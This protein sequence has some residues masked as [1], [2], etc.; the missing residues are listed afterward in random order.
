MTASGRAAIVIPAYEPTQALA[1]VVDELAAD[2]RDIIVV[3]DGSSP[4]AG[5][6]FSQIA[7]HR[8]VVI[9]RHAINLGKGQAL[10]TAFNYFLLHGSPLASG[11]VTAD[12]DGQHLATDIRRVAEALEASP[13]RLILGTRRFEGR[14]PF[15]SRIGNAVT[16]AMFRMLLGRSVA[17]TQSG[18]RGIPRRFLVE[19]LTI[20]AGRYEYE[21][22]VLI[23]AAKRRLPI[24]AVPIR[25]VYGGAGQ[26]HF[27]VLR[28]SVRIYFVFV[29]FLGLSLA[30]AALDYAV[31]V[32]AYLATR[33]LLAS[34]AIARTVA[35]TFNFACNRWFVFR[36]RGRVWPQA[37]KYVVLVFSL[38]WISYAIV[39]S[40]I[41][42]TGVGVYIAKLLGDGA[43]FVA[44]FAVQQSLVFPVWQREAGP[45]ASTDWD[46]YYRQPARFAWITR[47]VTARR[48]LTIVDRFMPA[49]AVRHVVEL[50]GGNSLTLA[51]FADH[52]PEARLTAVDANAFGLQLLTE[53]VAGDARLVTV[54]ADALTLPPTFSADVVY[55]T[56]L[57]EHFA[58]DGTARAVAAHFD[59]VRPGGLV[60]ITYPTP[61]W[62]Y[63]LVRAGATVL[64]V[65]AFPDERPL[66]HDEVAR[67]AARHGRVLDLSINW[68]V[69]LTQGVLVA[70]RDLQS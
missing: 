9:L 53:R 35:G 46:R 4:G 44:S 6:L 39:T 8:G 3:D 32:A 12:A 15:R 43:L 22:E 61:T 25:T 52:Y 33:H 10:K 27:N 58:P 55:S 64:G 2:G 24:D 67:E 40:L 5:E 68:A 45:A 23:R 29:R 70:R 36:A 34:I 66:R 14:V 30:T 51:R 19:L 7:R 1:R 13:D 56:G 18:L 65:W 42:F 37:L 20:E 47:R 59:Q 69:L 63:R 49:A 31:F 28:D 60:V 17:D 21:L 26:S 62:L 50:G 16:R 54:N 41:L 57:V 38:M 48:L 11:V